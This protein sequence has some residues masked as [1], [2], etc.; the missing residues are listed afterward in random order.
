[1]VIFSFVCKVIE[2][3]MVDKK[4]INIE[5]LVEAL[6]KSWSK[7]SC[8]PPIQKKWSNKNPSFGQC[9][10]TVLIVQDYLGG[11]ILRN[12]DY[13][14]YWNRLPN[15]KE[16]DLTRSQFGNEVT[17]RAD[18][19]VSR[20]YILE[21][22]SANRAVTLERYRLLKKRVEKYLSKKQ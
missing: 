20:K 17:I 12:K 2:L 14:H 5:L 8:Y 21:S 22:N 16:I 6:R 3:K 7:E 11:D 1:M 13:H 18:D 15:G 19:I 10:V 4:T 9:A